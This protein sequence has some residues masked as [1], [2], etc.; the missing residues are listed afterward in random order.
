MKSD[1]RSCGTKPCL[2]WVMLVGVAILIAPPRGSAQTNLATLRGT[3]TDPSGAAVPNAAVVLTNVATNAIRTTVSNA[4]GDYEVPYLDPGTYRLDCTASGFEKF[5]AQDVAIVSD[6]TRRVDVQMHIGSASTLVTVTAGAAVIATENAQMTGGY[7]EAVYKDSPLS[8]QEFPSAQM[9]LSPLVQSN[10]GG[11]GLVIAGLPTTQNEESMD[12]M[13][14]DGP[15][16]LV[17]DVH[18]AEDVQITTSNSP[19]EFS[20]AVNFSITG[21]SGSNAFHGK[22][23]FDEINSALDARFSL[24][25]TKIPFKTHEGFGDFSGPLKRDRTFF[26]VGSTLI[27]VPSE[28]FYYENVP[29]AAERQGNFAQSSTPIINP[30]TGTQFPGNII[31]IPFSSVG[32]TIQQKYI[33]LPNIGSATATG[34]NFGYYWPHPTDLFKIAYWNVRVDHNFS[35]KHSLFGRYSNRISPYLL[36]GS[37]P[38][39]GTWTRNRYHDSWVASDIYSLTPNL[40][41]NFRWGRALDHIHDG[42]PELGYT[43]PTGDVAV[44]AIGLQGVNPNAYKIMGFPNTTIT[45]VSALTQQPGGLTLNTVTYS[46]TEALTWAKGRHVAKFG[47][48][49]R[50]WSNPTT[51]YPAG[52]Y[53]AFTYDGR[54]TVASGSSANAYNAYADFLL[55]LPGTSARLNPIVARDSFANEQGY[56]AEDVFKVTSKLTL[57]YGLRWERFGF[58]TYQDGLVYNWDQTT[59]NVIV[60]QAELAKINPLYPTNIIKVVGGQAVPSA[61]NTL[62]RP[63]VG[64]AYRLSDQFVIR[65]GYGMFTNAI[66][67]GNNGGPPVSQTLLTTPA[68]FQLTESYNNSVVNNTPLL[69]MPNPYPSSLSS[70][71]VPGQAVTGFP[72]NTVNGIIH[73]FS[74]S[75]ERQVHSFGLSVSYVGDRGKGLN[76]AVAQTDIPQPSTTAF[77][78]SSKPYTQFVT[79]AFWET[80]GQT[81]YDALI[82][83]AKRRLG[84]FSFDTHYTYANSMSSYLDTEDVYSLFHWNH[85][86]Y[87]ARSRFVAEFIYDLPFGRGQRWGGNMPLAAN[88]VLGGWHGNW[89][90]TFQSGQYFTPSYTGSD[91]SNTNIFGGIPDRVCN[92]NLASSARGPHA[93]F[94][95][96][97]F[98]VPQVGRFG[99]SGVDVL[100]GPRNIVSSMTLGKEF[101]VKEKVRI[102]FEGLLIDLF[103]TPAYA[104]PA[105]NISAPGTVGQISSP[106]GGLGNGGGFVEAGAERQIVLRLRIEF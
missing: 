7:T 64:V 41:N 105:A 54:M 25:P 15:N 71:V 99:N 6:E 57:N 4:S 20:R 101:R 85:D 87:T 38:N 36:N 56:Y 78:A 48:D 44:G 24:N 76:Y 97:C 94:N 62:F 69:S 46:Y 8:S 5:V 106:L 37:F 75:V 50:H 51:Q 53:G 22:A 16:N 33:P 98:A 27:F 82:L 63:R 81:K 2:W 10:Q 95:P 19:A 67:T 80:N 34:N 92:G 73:E 26:Y 31:N 79:T 13:E 103:N 30:Y 35:S 49:I 32:T 21:K 28:S 45:G 77:V 42:I 23:D 66:A 102:N 84:R 93:W 39:V 40:V 43:P 60:P 11:F 47:A 1:S 90:S 17:N 86:A 59:G 96:S 65:G 91:P 3:V 14:N 9:L 68:P 74:V 18:Y 58:P 100:E 52:T 70:A 89:V 104:F 83:E 12:G 55:G 72:K 61:D 88:A 29:D